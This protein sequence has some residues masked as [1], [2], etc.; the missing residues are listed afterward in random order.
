MFQ[1]RGRGARGGGNRSSR[2]ASLVRGL[3]LEDDT[4][5]CKLTDNRNPVLELIESR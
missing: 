5:K 1:R 2:D 3:L 4:W